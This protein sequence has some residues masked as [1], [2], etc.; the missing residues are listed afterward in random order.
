MQQA[1]RALPVVAPAQQQHVS[2][3]RPGYPLQSGAGVKPVFPK[4]S[5]SLPLPDL[6][7]STVKSVLLLTPNPAIFHQ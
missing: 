2:R 4:C 7:Q 1:A 5:F 6:Q 3:R